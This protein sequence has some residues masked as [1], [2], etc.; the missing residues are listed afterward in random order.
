MIENKE[1]YADKKKQNELRK[2]DDAAGEERERRLARILAAKIALHHQLIRAVSCGR[3]KSS[4]NYTRP[5]G[6]A[7]SQVHRKVEQLKLVKLVAHHD[8]FAPASGNSREQ[9][10]GGH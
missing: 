3:Q 5:E 8:D 10:Y 7:T 6:I 4:T 9:D 1:H 2:N